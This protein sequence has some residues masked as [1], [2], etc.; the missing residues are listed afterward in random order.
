MHRLEPDNHHPPDSH[1][2][3]LS[4]A[5]P[6]PQLIYNFPEQLFG[7]A[8]VMSIEHA[9]FDG[10]ERLAAVTGGEIAST[11]DHPELVRLG[12][13]KLIEEIMVGEDRML[14]FSGV[15][16]GEACTIV[17]RGSS[18]HLLDEAERSLHDALAVLTETCKETRISFGGGCSEVRGKGGGMRGGNGDEEDRKK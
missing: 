15:K 14:R 4:R 7:E 9:D 17:L 18:G 13:A 3:A 11:F 12:E 2:S 8:G 5:R 6:R 16:A 10:I 1:R